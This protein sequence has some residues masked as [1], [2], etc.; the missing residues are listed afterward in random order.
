LHTRSTFNS[1]GYISEVNGASHEWNSV[2]TLRNSI[3]PWS[4]TWDNWFRVILRGGATVEYV[5]TWG[6][7]KHI[8]RGPIFGKQKW[9]LKWKGQSKWGPGPKYNTRKPPVTPSKSNTTW[10]LF[11]NSYEKYRHVRKCN[12]RK[13]ISLKTSRFMNWTR[14]QLRISIK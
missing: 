9:V 3:V 2:N 6:D 14:S 5:N 8:D 12:Y 1:T 10:C 13:W 11:G 7:L 4:F